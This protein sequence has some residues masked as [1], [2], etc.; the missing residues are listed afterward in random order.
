MTKTL[1]YLLIT[2]GALT[3]AFVVY[4]FFIQS[5]EIAPRDET[6]ASLET[7][8]S[9]TAIFIS[10]SQE[11]DRINF[12]LSLFEDNR[13]KSLQL[14]TSPVEDEAVGKRDLFQEGN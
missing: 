4:Y 3:I 1:K 13:F 8:L 9:N 7:M 14:Y 10:H 11:L 2:L 12:D 6:A 5:A